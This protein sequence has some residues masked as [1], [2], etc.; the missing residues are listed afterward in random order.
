MPDIATKDTSKDKGHDSCSQ[1]GVMSTNQ[2]IVTVNGSPVVCVGDTFQKHGCDD[3][4][5]HSPVVAEGSSILSINGKP[6]AYVGCKLSGCPS[7]NEIT[8]G[9]GLIDIKE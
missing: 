5:P 4:P 3:H 9:D 2:T 6:V 8:T 7:P 1:V